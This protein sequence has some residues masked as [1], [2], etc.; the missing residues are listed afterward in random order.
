MR[1]IIIL[2]IGLFL[3]CTNSTQAQSLLK[4]DDIIVVNDKVNDVTVQIKT[5]NQSQV[6]SSRITQ[7]KVS[8]KAGYTP[9]FNADNTLLTLH[10]SKKFNDVELQTLL[11]YS[12]IELEGKAFKQLYHLIN[13]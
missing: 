4:V 11:K 9:T 7:S 2:C 8:Q 1:K 5:T 3:I 10:F 13:R 6:I 12:G